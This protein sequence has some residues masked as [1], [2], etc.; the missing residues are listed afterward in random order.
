VVGH[1]GKDLKVAPRAGFDVQR[2]VPLVLLVLLV[3]LVQHA[4]G[5]SVK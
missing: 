3:R 4:K 5:V 1:F 2:R